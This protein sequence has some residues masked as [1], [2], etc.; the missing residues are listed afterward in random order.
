MS[1]FNFQKYLHLSAQKSFQDGIELYGKNNQTVDKIIVWLVG[2]SITVIV[3]IITG[4]KK[5]IVISDSSKSLIIFL[6]F[7]TIFIG[8]IQRIM[9][10][11]INKIE[12]DLKISFDQYIAGY[13][14][15]E[16]NKYSRLFSKYN[17]SVEDVIKYLE[18]DFGFIYD[19][20]I[21]DRN[22][23]EYKNLLNSLIEKYDEKQDKL[24]EFEV[25]LFTESYSKQIGYDLTSLNNVNNKT[26]SKKANIFKLLDIANVLFYVMCFTFIM[27]ILTAV[28]SYLISTAVVS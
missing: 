11:V 22:S 4:S 12:I 20:N 18:K 26:K 9:M 6:A 27:A 28:V 17:S 25:N 5:E 1:E 3:L 21:P 19:G 10:V 2:F 13:M 15:P 23:D 16:D 8:V 7:L 14:I 24:I